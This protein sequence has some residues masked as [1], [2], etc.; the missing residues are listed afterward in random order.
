M[1]VNILSM[2]HITKSFSDRILLD[3][4]G[5]GLQEGEKV[6]VIGI[7]GMGKST[8]LKLIAGIEQPDDG[9]ITKGKN[10]RIG[11]LSQTPVFEKDETLLGLVSKRNPKTPEE[12]TKESEAKAMLAALGF[13]EFNQKLSEL[14]GGQ[15]KRAVLVETLLNPVDILILDE[16]TNHLDDQMSQ[17]LEDRL[18][19]YRGTLIMV[20][21]DRYFLDRVAT[22]IVEVDRG[23][24]Y[25]YPGSYSKYLEQKAQRLDIEQASERKRQSILTTELKWLARG[26]RARSTKQ[27]AH[28]QRIE[29]MQNVKTP[30]LDEKLTLS[31]VSSRLGNTTIEAEHLAKSYGG[32]LLFTDY[33]HIF[34]K[35]ER[36]GIT[37]PNGCGKTTLLKI[38]HGDIEPDHGS[39]TVGATVKIGYFAQEYA[40]MN[41]DLKAIEYVREGAEYIQTKE[42]KITASAM[43]ERFLFDSTMQWTR[44]EKLS[45][46]EKRRLYLL[47]ILMDAPNVLILDE[48]TNDLDIPTLN[49]LEDYLDNF[50]GIV[51]VVS[52]DRYFLDRVVQ[53]I[54]AFEEEGKIRQYEGGYSDYLI[55]N[56]DRR[57]QDERSVGKSLSES[58]ETSIRKKSTEKPRHNQKL[59]FT[60][61]EQRE[62]ETID[63][64]ISSLEEHITKTE[65]QIQNAA[66]DF[67]KLNELSEKKEKLEKEL[68]EKTE[69]WIYL[70]DLDE[71][72]KAQS[73]K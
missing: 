57:Q 56:A 61:K 9:E 12:F 34:L 50:D 49:V 19:G 21:H 23:S 29:D 40:P 62:F 53:R 36:V 43:M 44:I 2:E 27:K 22:R 13:T 4:I 52:H 33:S 46:G 26:A 58:E 67:V 5:F 60:F 39:V 14:S 11:Y 37:G 47:R 25:S 68:E 42:G 31:S 65:D 73:S 45:G 70:T 59:K 17:W 71:K 6:G 10:I 54:L 55:A 32:K 1:Q 63:T 30:V 64:E 38:I 16:P 7:N 15:R 66:T 8:L 18:I 41:D 20:T 51:I 69:R 3:D 35:D 24:L 72:I 48:P 28:I